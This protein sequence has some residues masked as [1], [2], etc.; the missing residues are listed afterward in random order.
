MRRITLI[1]ALILCTSTLA[2]AWGVKGHKTVAQISLSFLSDGAREEIENLLG[3]VDK[4]VEASIWADQ[5]RFMRPETAPWHF[6][7][8]PFPSGTFDAATLCPNNDCLLPRIDEFAKR[9]A[10]RS[11]T[12]GVR[13]EALK[14]VIHLVGDVHQPLHAADDNDRGG[15]EVFVTIAGTTDKLHSWWDTGLVADLGADP[16]DVAEKVI[17]HIS[18]ADAHQWSAGTSQQWA[19]EFFAIAK[20]LCAEPGQEHDRHS[21]HSAGVVHH[22]RQ[23]HHRAS[24]GYGRRSACLGH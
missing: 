2:H 21:H 7:D 20:D 6:V 5:I 16:S 9:M 11:L 17:S 1:L 12:R 22:E 4:Y 23:A 8:L 10:D 24:V 15:N 13:A 3:S 14:W 18:G 19:N